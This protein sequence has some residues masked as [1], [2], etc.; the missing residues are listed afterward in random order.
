MTG[1]ALAG[2]YP[3]AMKLMATWFV[4]GRGL[5][6]GI[7]IGT[8][9]F[10][11]SMPHLFRAFSNGLDWQVVVI[12]T[13][14]S[15]LLSAVIFGILVKEGPHAFA[16]AGLTIISIWLMPH[17]AHLLGGWEWALIA[18]LPGP[19]IGIWAM[20]RLRRLPEAAQL[21]GGRR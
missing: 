7:L 6:M 14:F 17:V 16:R 5:V 15:A 9:V 3:P 8:L 11:S 12:L 13:S 20:L 19:V 1:I 18:L 2:I 4:R 21:G 10:G